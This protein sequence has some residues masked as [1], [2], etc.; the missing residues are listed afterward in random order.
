MYF[1]KTRYYILS[2]FSVDII[3]R[4]L[5]FVKL[6]E[7]LKEFL[8]DSDP[9][10][11]AVGVLVLASVLKELPPD[12]LSEDEINF[13]VAFFCDRL[14]DHHDVIPATLNGIFAMVKSYDISF[15][16]SCKNL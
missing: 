16:V 2:H 9:A 12:F 3:S 6:V 1:D 7:F 14:K 13:I 8:T 5:E 10:Q 4:R 11:R 15:S